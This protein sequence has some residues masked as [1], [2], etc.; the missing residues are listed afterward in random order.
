VKLGK[1]KEKEKKTGCA[2]NAPK[3]EKG[4]E[5]GKSQGEKKEIGGFSV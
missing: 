3:G 4:G 5:R 1:R 2:K